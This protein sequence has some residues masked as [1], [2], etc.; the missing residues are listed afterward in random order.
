MPAQTIELSIRGLHT[1]NSELSGVP[2]GALKR[3]RNISINRLNLAEPRRGFNFL[4]HNLPNNSDRAQR[5]IDFKDSLWAHTGTELFYSDGSSFV[6]RGTIS[7][8]SGQ[9]LRHAIGNQ[10]LYLSTSNGIYKTDAVS[11]SVTLAGVPK[12][13]HLTGAL[14]GASGY[15]TDAGTVAYRYLFGRYDLNGN[16][17][18]GGASQRITVSNNVG[19]GATRN[20]QLRLYIPSGILAGDFLQLYRTI[21]FATGVPDEEYQLSYELTLTSGDISAGYVDITDIVQDDLLGA[22]LYVSTSQGG[23]AENNE[24]MPFGKSIEIYKE[25]LFL[26]N[27]RYRHKILVTL[28]ATG[29]NGLQNNDTITFTRGVTTVTY[30]AKSSPTL[31]TDFQLTTG[32]TASTDIRDTALAFVAKVNQNAS[33]FLYAYYI[34]GSDDLPGKILLEA[35]DLSSSSFTVTSTRASAFQP[36]LTSP[37]ATLNTSSSSS[38]KNGLAFSKYGQSEHFALKNLIFIGRADKELLNIKALRDA[39][40]VFKEDGTFVL[41]GDNEFNFTVQEVDTNA[42]LLGV[43]CLCVGNN[44][45]YCYLETGFAAVTDAGTETISI[46][47]KDELLA[48]QGPALAEIEAYSHAVAYDAEGKILF[49]VPEAEGDTTATKVY[50][51]DFYNESFVDWPIRSD[52]AV[53]FQKR[54]YAGVSDI[55]KI[56]VERKALDFSDY[57]D[58]GSS[59]TISDVSSYTLTLNDTSDILPG[60]VIAQDDLYGYVESV[61]PDLDTV[62]LDVAEAWDTGLPVDHLKGIDVD[63]AFNPEFAGNPGGYKNWLECL[64]MFKRGFIKNATISFY[65][66]LYSG[67]TEVPVEQPAGTGAFGEFD[68]GDAT[69]GGDPAQAPI[70]LLVPRDASKSTLLFVSF[71]QRVAFSDFQLNGLSLIYE[72]I[73]TRF[74]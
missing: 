12:A 69:F 26:G 35:R 14:T 49:W 15:L 1:Y 32:G 65:T 68:F 34:S 47:I 71:S 41:R 24:N 11:S 44:T 66:D 4:T 50:V 42:V 37:A 70:R 29:T 19:G 59:L 61:N 56:R 27:L 18:L 51:Y 52:A 43:D 13:I 10:N 20:V 64:L 36:S 16:L 53:I 8:P 55:N 23:I 7:A 33:D 25:H 72:P 30:T 45:A 67:L 9:K 38:Y 48:I 39:L 40:L 57:V 28:L 60:D 5:L 58:Y 74:I 22:F 46:P 73:S 6:S 63:V 17:I 62:T 21:I 3:G 31:S 54:L 2:K